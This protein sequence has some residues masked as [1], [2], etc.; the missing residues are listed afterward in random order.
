MCVER[1][2]APVAN[3]LRDQRQVNLSESHTRN[4]H[5]STVHS[6]VVGVSIQ[7]RVRSQMR[8]G[9][10]VDGQSESEGSVTDGRNPIL[11]TVWPLAKV[12]QSCIVQLK[13]QVVLVVARP[14]S[15]GRVGR[16]VVVSIQ[17]VQRRSLGQTPCTNN[18]SPPT[19]AQPAN[20]DPRTE[21]KATCRSPSGGSVENKA[22]SHR[23]NVGRNEGNVA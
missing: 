8:F 10:K 2:I 22:V 6:G 18:P 20:F 5:G 11:P 16:R 12:L 15:Q 9:E 23:C 21:V 19:S 1:F 3:S 17:S 13:G 14:G 7:T 4:K